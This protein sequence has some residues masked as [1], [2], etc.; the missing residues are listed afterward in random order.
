MRRTTSLRLAILATAAAATVA[1]GG[2]ASVSAA[3]AADRSSA[4]A[5]AC[6]PG[7]A[8]VAAARV[9]DGSRLQEP[10]LFPDN[11][12]K[13]Y[14]ALRDAP[15]LGNGSVTI[16]TVFHIVSDHTLSAAERARFDRL[17]TAQMKVLNDSFSG[18]TAPDAADTPFRFSLAKTDYT[19]NAAWHEATPSSREERAMKRSLHEGDARTLNVYGTEGGGLLGWAYFPKGYNTGNA[20]LD[21][22]V[23]M[24]ES[25]PGGTGEG[26]PQYTGGDTLTHEVGHWLALHHTFNAGCSAAGDFVADTPKEAFPQFG[27][28]VGADTCAAP[29]LD[30]I[31]NFM[32]Y[33]EDACMNMFTRGQAERMSDAWV[34]WR[35]EGGKS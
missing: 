25:M 27:C 35:A 11:E 26:Y 34:A 19:V 16:P 22:V 6:E 12:A 17:I 20:Y 10:K 14:G 18:L 7:S 5:A 3:P 15:Y 1:T 4:G 31:H 28:P 9:P 29:G 30:P 2:A 13:A 23:M 21:G 32:D 24:A 8:E 33:T